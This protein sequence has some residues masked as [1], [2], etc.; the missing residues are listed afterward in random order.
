MEGA[1][2]LLRI[3]RR[4]DT[5]LEPA[6]PTCVSALVHDGLVVAETKMI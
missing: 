1:G 2:D 6:V 5:G 4:V 3:A